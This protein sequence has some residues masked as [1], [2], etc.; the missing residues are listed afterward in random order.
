MR[1]T[2]GGIHRCVHGCD[3][4][5]AICDQPSTGLGWEM[6]TQTEKRGKPVLAV[7]H[8]RSLVTALVLDPQQPGYEFHRYDSLLKDVPRLVTERLR[9]METEREALEQ[10][11]Y[12]LLHLLGESAA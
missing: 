5:L 12:P 2:S 7:A 6:A 3:L 1:S 9:R 8:K 11:E 10:E 4:L